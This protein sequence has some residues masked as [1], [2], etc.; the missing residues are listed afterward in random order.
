MTTLPDHLKLLFRL[1]WQPAAAMSAIL[2]RGSLLFASV[3]VLVISLVAPS[4]AFDFFTP[5]L[6]LAGVYVP[7]TLLIAQLIGVGTLV[8]FVFTFSYIANWVIDI[9]IGQRVSAADELAG[10]DIPE[11][12][13]LG[14]PEFV[15]KPQGE[16]EPA[17]AG[18]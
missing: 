17:L 2:D 13:A 11:M 4:R 10:L 12:G 8:G 7:G 9:V 1:F 6:L 3:T 15:L 5:L 14:Y 18:D 16:A